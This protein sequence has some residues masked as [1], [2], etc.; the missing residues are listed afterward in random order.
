MCGFSCVKAEP[1]AL[2]PLPFLPPLTEEKALPS[3]GGQRVALTLATCVCP[4]LQ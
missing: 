4:R 2:E 1:P 3:V